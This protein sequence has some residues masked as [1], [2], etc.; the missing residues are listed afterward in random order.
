MRATRALESSVVEVTVPF[1]FSEL[2][3]PSDDP[4]AWGSWFVVLTS[5]FLF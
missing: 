1:K 3:D 4:C 5:R 2:G